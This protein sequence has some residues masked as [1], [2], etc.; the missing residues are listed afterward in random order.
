VCRSKV[1]QEARNQRTEVRFVVDAAIVVGL[2]SKNN[3]PR[4]RERVT[5][6][7]CGHNDVFRV[8]NA[9]NAIVGFK[10]VKDTTTRH[11]KKRAAVNARWRG[12]LGP[13]TATARF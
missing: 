7:E 8:V 5:N 1:D 2:L 6:K 9:N 13:T 11:N 10:E 4:E 12:K 3:A